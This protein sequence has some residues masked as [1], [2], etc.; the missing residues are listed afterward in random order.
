MR[1]R[2][3]RISWKVTNEVHEGGPVEPYGGPLRGPLGTVRYLARWAGEIQ[4][5]FI[6]LFL[7]NKM[8]IIGH[9]EVG[10]GGGASCPVSTAAVCRAAVA[11]GA[12]AIIVAHNHPSGDVTPS[13]ADVTVTLNLRRLCE[14]LETPLLDHVIVGVSPTGMV[15]HKSLRDLGLM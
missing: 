8:K 13:D 7:D 14:A 12:A 9:Q 15:V 10:R 6:V 4:E 5:V 1:R 11:S 2:E 3:L